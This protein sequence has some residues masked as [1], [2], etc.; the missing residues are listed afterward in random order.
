MKERM[1]EILTLTMMALALGMDAFSAS[2][3]LGMVP[4][5]LKRIFYIGLIVGGLHV[6]LPLVGMVAGRALSNTFGEVANI[7]GGILLMIAG[8]Q[9]IVSVLKE[10][11]SGRSIPSGWSLFL[12]AIVVSLDSFSVGLTL[13]IYGARA[14]IVL[15]LFG[16][17]AAMLTWSGLLLG[18]KTR[19]LLGPYSEAFGGC[20]L[21]IFGIKLLFPI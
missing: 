11:E 2:L 16:G 18:K 21:L 1:G 6:G 13:G 5:R 15:S 8:V 10:E 20:V 7:I 12:F 9:M 19:G 3:S 14:V 17:I 4:I